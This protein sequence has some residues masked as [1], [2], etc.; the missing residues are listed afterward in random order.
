[1]L[2]TANSFINSTFKIYFICST[3]YKIEGLVESGIMDKLLPNSFI[4]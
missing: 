2:I 4:L 3:I 1:M